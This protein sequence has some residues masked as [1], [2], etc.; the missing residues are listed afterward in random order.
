MVKV[1]V[2]REFLWRESCQDQDRSIVYRPI[3]NN[4]LAWET[5]CDWTDS[6]MS[7]IDSFKFHAINRADSLLHRLYWISS[8]TPVWQLWRMFKYTD[9]E[10]IKRLWV[11][12]T[13]FNVK[14]YF[15]RSQGISAR[16]VSREGAVDFKV[17]TRQS[18]MIDLFYQRWKNFSWD[19]SKFLWKPTW[20]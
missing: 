6:S 15:C 19:F 17:K 13:W 12:L 16:I 11:L 2:S 1:E 10:S 5:V 3:N 14:K 20:H 18:Q 4:D 9:K 7:A 8:S